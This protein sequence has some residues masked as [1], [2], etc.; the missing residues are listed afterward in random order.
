MGNTVTRAFERSIKGV[1][2]NIFSWKALFQESIT[3]NKTCSKHHSSFNWHIT[4]KLL[5]RYSNSCSEITI[6][7]N[8]E[9]TYKHAKRSVISFIH[10]IIILKNEPYFCVF[11]IWEA[12]LIKVEFVIFVIY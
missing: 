5:I 10:I 7:K 4:L 3:V 2:A 1:S 9:K 8:Y 6:S 11:H 12:L